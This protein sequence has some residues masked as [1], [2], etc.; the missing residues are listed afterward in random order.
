LKGIKGVRLVNNLLCNTL[1][2]TQRDSEHPERFEQALFEAFKALGLKVE[3]L[4]GANE[5]DII[6]EV[7]NHKAIVDAKTTKEGVIS[8]RYVNFD[9]M[10]RYKA[11]Y[12]ADDMGI[13]APGFSSGNIRY[14]AQKR[15]IV[16]IETE[17]ICRLLENNAIYPYKSEQI[18]N[19]LFGKNK[20][21]IMPDDISPSTEEEQ[22]LIAIVRQVLTLKNIPSFTIEN[23]DFLM[24]DHDLI[25]EHGEI[26]ET[27][28]FLSEPPFNILRQEGAEYIFTCDPEN[29]KKKFGLVWQ[30][31]GLKPPPSKEDKLRGISNSQKVTAG[32]FIHMGGGIFYWK[33]DD[34]VRID[35]SKSGNE[36]EQALQQNRLTT[37]NLGSFYHFL[38]RRAGLLRKRT[39]R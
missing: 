5:P 19:N 39:G 3:Y 4:G 10:E 38:R 22:R 2:E 20:E 11:G 12:V 7:C 21:A 17:A 29:T 13:V 32:E 31:L 14:T 28:D 36:V 23:L 9:A 8:E 35:V 16:L 37:A 1:R 6:L 18:Y 26:R 15:G 30:A 25:F 34:S 24:H 33:K 27:L